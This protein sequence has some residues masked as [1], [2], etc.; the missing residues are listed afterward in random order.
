VCVCVCVRVC[1]RVCVI[2]LDD[3]AGVSL[4]L[5]LAGSRDERSHYALVEKLFVK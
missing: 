1:V 2:S 5:L 4:Y 3:I